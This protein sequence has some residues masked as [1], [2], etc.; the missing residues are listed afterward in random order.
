VRGKTYSLLDHPSCY[1]KKDDVITKNGEMGIFDREYIVCSGKCIQASTGK[2]VIESYEKMSK[3]KFNG[4]DPL[5]VIERDGVDMARLQLID[6]ASPRQ[7]I[8]WGKTQEA[9]IR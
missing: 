6:A 3:S 1:V 4:V 5:E 9:G 8:E 2:D 7:Y